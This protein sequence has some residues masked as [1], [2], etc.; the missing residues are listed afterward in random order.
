M[1]KNTKLVY[2]VKTK[3]MQDNGNYT[4]TKKHLKIVHT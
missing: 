3:K 2:W 1:K 4:Y